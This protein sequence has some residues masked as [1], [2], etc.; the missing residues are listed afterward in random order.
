MTTVVSHLTGPLMA[1]VSFDITGSYTPAFVFV[2][3]L[4]AVGGLSL[5]FAQPSKEVSASGLA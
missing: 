3:V 5:I 2:A 1:G 4:F